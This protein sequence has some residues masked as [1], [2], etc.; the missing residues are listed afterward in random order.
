MLIKPRAA[1]A[2][3]TG[4]LCHCATNIAP[5]RQE[6]PQCIR[7]T[8]RIEGPLQFPRHPQPSSQQQMAKLSN[9]YANPMDWISTAHSGARRGEEPIQCCVA[10]FKQSKVPMVFGKRTEIECKITSHR[11]PRRMK[12]T[13]CERRSGCW[14]AGT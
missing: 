7:H 3:A 11:K 13:D 1:A 12:G 9:N 10:A 2:H 6:P 8:R 4:L 14:V 5:L